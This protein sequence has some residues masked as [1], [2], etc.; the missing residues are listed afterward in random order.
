[1]SCLTVNWPMSSIPVFGVKLHPI[2]GLAL[3]RV[4]RFLY[5]HAHELNLGYVWLIRGAG[6]HCGWPFA[7]VWRRCTTDRR[8]EGNVRCIGRAGVLLAEVSG[9]LRL[10]SPYFGAYHMAYVCL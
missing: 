7:D 10:S 1:M 5:V 9:S 6:D 3:N 8:S 2:M 4:R